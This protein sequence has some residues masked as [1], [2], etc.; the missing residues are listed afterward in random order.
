MID[1]LSPHEMFIFITA[2]LLM[3]LTILRLAFLTMLLIH[4]AHA[5][6]NER[7]NSY[8]ESLDGGDYPGAAAQRAREMSARKDDAEL[9]TYDAVDEADEKDAFLPPYSERS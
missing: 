6:A 2:S 7:P 9:P 8:A 1:S 3:V 4:R 5:Y